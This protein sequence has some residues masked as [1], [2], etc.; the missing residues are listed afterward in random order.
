MPEEKKPGNVSGKAD[1]IHVKGG[2]G[3][4]STSRNVQK[5]KEAVS[6]LKKGQK[7]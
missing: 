4:N 3:G 2:Q 7:R 1:V 6:E 5:A